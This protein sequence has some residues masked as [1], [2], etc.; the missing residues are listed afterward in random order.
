MKC[1]VH[2]DKTFSLTMCPTG[3]NLASYDL[4]HD[5]KYLDLKGLYWCFSIGCTCNTEDYNPVWREATTNE[6]KRFVEAL[7]SVASSCLEG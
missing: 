5:E 1:Y 4:T 6:Q 7:L 3:E 2:K